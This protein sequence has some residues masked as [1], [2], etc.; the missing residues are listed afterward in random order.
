MHHEERAE[1]LAAPSE[2]ARLLRQEVE[3]VGLPY[4]ELEPYLARA[5]RDAIT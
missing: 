5:P 4:V 2:L 1:T 3:A